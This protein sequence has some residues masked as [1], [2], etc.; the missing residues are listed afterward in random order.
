MTFRISRRGLLGTSA[1]IVLAF[2]VTTAAEAQVTLTYL[3]DDN[4]TNLA[5]AE[6]LKTAFEAEN[7][8]IKIE[9]ETRPGGGEGDNIIKTRLATGEMTDVF[10]YNA[11]SLF[12]ALNPAQTLVDLTDEPWQAN[13]LDSFKQVVTGP[14]GRIYGAPEEA[15]M[16]GGI[17]YNKKIYEEL[18]LSVPKTWDEFMANNQKIKDA[19]K[20]A[21]IQTF[22][23]T[24]TSQLF[25][26]GD[27]FNVQAAVP[28]FAADYTAGKAKYATTPAAMRGFEYG[29]QVYEAGFLNEDFAA[30]TFNDGVR[31]VATGEGAHYPMLTF[32]IGGIAQ[33]YPEN[34]NDVGFFAIP[35][36][37]AEPNGVTVWMPAAVYIPRTTEHLEE[38]K[39]FVAF[40]A[41]TKGCDARTA[42][43]GATGPYVIKGCELPA[44]VPPAVADLQTYF[45]QDGTTA[46][47]LEF[48]SPVK[49]P[50]LEQIT[51][52]VGSGIR[53]A[54]EA[55]ALYDED[56][57][58]Q[59]QQLGLPGWE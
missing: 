18:G 11:G 20:V 3:I 23:D 24:W 21:V 56:V 19:G 25:V 46:P 34:L 33:D 51:V 10:R 32:A 6:Q 37:E 30:A 39:R 43:N 35:G 29:Q 48:V 47:A 49:G 12:Q 58:K 13:V 42:A 59:A 7:P 27:F 50:A 28:N 45:N 57:R 9:I 36:P 22:G 15:A 40:I 44:D 41:S 17:L 54:A 38:A 52:E 5:T 4:P 16:G 26:L 8:D 14:D 1:G 53:P 31:M 2:G 55:A